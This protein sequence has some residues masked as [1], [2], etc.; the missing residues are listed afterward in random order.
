MSVTAPPPTQGRRSPLADAGNGSSRPLV[1]QRTDTVGTELVFPS[2]TGSRT[3]IGSAVVAGPLPHTTRFRAELDAGWT[4]HALTVTCEG[5]HWRR[6][7]QMTRDHDGTWSCRT[8]ETGHLGWSPAGAGHAAP[9]APGIEHP[10]RLTGARV[11]RLSDSPIFATWALRHLQ[12]A[13][14]GRAI[15]AAT[16]RVLTPSLVVLSTRSAYQLISDHRLQI[17]GGERTTTYE[18][19]RTG[20]V[21]SQPARVRLAR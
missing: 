1:W 20:L 5:A 4:I 7:L 12:L 17:S 2:G 9:P 13:A 14:G 18:L 8:E 16:I 15:T 3:T 11:L 10:D 6:E 19:D 21:L